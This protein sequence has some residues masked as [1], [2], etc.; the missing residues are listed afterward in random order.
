MRRPMLE[1]SDCRPVCRQQLSLPQGTQDIPPA[2]LQELP[3]IGSCT[4]IVK[5]GLPGRQ[6]VADISV[7]RHPF[8]TRRTEAKLTAKLEVL[9]DGRLGQNP[10]QPAIVDHG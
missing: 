9:H 8:L 2:L 1:I 7:C 10:Y 6:G 3:L 5:K 4:M